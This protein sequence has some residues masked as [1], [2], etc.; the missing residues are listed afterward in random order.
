MDSPTNAI[1]RQRNKWVAAVNSGSADAFVEVI[2]DDAVWLPAQMDAVSGKERVRNWLTG[3]F[4]QYQFDYSVTDVR[5]RVAGEWAVEQA[6][7]ATVVSSRNGDVLPPHEG[8]YVVVWRRQ[9]DTWLIE[10]YVDLSAD[11][12]DVE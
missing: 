1:A 5:L 4:S 8:S 6:R 7:F 10:S 11:F 12:V 3:P 9:G 2:V